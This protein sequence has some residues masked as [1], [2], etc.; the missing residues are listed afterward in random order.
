ML[1]RVGPAFSL[2]R[3]LA[4]LPFFVLGAMTPPDWLRLLRYPE[5][6]WAGALVLAGTAIAVA[7]ALRARDLAD[8]GDEER[9]VEPVAEPFGEEVIGLTG[10][11]PDRVEGGA[12]LGT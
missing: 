10:G 1:E 6:R 4:L 2:A 5:L 7:A 3:I 9:A 8:D 12:G 11:G